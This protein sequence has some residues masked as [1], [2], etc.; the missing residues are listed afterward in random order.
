MSSAKVPRVPPER[1]TASETEVVEYTGPQ[2]RIHRT[3]GTHVTAWNEHRRFGPLTSMRF[4]PHPESSDGPSF[5]S[6]AG[7]HYSATDVATAVAEVFQR[8]RAVD[9][10]AGRPM[11]TGWTPVRPLLLLDLGGSWALRHGAAQSLASALRSVCRAWA[12]SIA[13]ELPEFDGIRAPSTMT[14]AA[15]IV[16]WR[17]AA[18]ALPAAP[19]FSR[20]LD[21]PDVR[22]MLDPICETIGYR[23]L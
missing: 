2:W 10:L 15:N 20:P 22:R 1:L 3:S 23:L 6:T 14:G 7:V 12:R 9:M 19:A 17:R 8:G 16:L 5:H 11:L 13:T 18:D 4:D 21:H